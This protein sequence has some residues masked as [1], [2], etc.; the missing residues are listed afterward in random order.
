MLCNLTFV[1]TKPWITTY[2]KESTASAQ[3]AWDKFPHTKC[4]L[5]DGNKSMVLSLLHTGF[6]PARTFN[7][8]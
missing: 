5:I 4:R 8:A 3:N 1:G 7:V 2:H 6:L